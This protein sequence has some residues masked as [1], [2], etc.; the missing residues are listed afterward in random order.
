MEEQAKIDPRKGIYRPYVAMVLCLIVMFGWALDVDLMRRILKGSIPMNPLEALLIFG[1]ALSIR[2]RWEGQLTGWRARVAQLAAALM[3]TMGSVRLFDA[4]VGSRLC[5]DYLLFAAELGPDGRISTLG[6]ICNILLGAGLL[7]LDKGST[8][9][10]FFHPQ[11]IPAPIAPIAMFSLA[12]WLFE[13]SHMATPGGMTPLGVAPAY[14]YALIAMAIWSSRRSTG[15]MSFITVDTPGARMVRYMLI[16][17]CALPLMLTSF[18]VFGIHHDWFTPERGAALLVFSAVITIAGIT[19]AI[20][21]RLQVLD[22]MRRKTLRDLKDRIA[23]DEAGGRIA[24]AMMKIEEVLRSTTGSPQDGAVRLLA[25]LAEFISV[26]Q[27]CLY[28]MDDGAGDPELT[29]MACHAPAD[30][31]QMQQRIALGEGLVG[32]CAVLRRPLFLDDVPKDYFRIRSGTLDLVPRMITFLPLVV[33]D[34][35]IGVLEIATLR[36]FTEET[37]EFLVRATQIMAFA[38]FRMREQLRMQ[39]LLN[40]L[41]SVRGRTAAVPAPAPG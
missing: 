18:A 16:A 15:P 13:G 29:V 2:L 11:W 41:A 37:R 40:D 12:D 10:M 9:E 20:S 36:S 31:R 30:L 6:A 26:P 39:R 28:V 21:T 7:L 19:V 3:L 38:L 8:Q 14:G 4:L 5:P 22:N 17:A 23:K 32:Q 1:G 33:N 27:L 25:F 35:T 24:A 34:E